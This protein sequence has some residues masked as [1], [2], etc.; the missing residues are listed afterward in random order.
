M[1][2]RISYLLIVTM[3]FMASGCGNVYSG[4]SNT[5]SDDAIYEDVQKLADEKNWSQALTEIATLSAGRQADSDVI[6]TWA[7]LLAGKCGLDFITYFNTISNGTLTGSTPIKFLMNAFTQVAVDPGS[8]ELAQAKLEEISTDPN[9]RTQ[10]ENLFMAILGMVKIGTY[11]RSV[12]DLDGPGGLG[13]GAADTGSGYDSCSTTALTDADVAQVVTGIGLVSNNSSALSAVAGS[14]DITTAMASISAVC[15]ST[16][17]KT[18]ASTVTGTD[19]TLVRDILKTGPSTTDTS[20]Q[21]GIDDQ[22]NASDG[23]TL[24]ACC[25]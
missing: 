13:D 23:V 9:Q 1:K 21:L 25:P 2:K 8:C 24:L 16:C 19:I 5:T 14:S 7:G 3:T 22:C 20:Y 17:A 18:D 10:S 12:A 15:G 11:L 6:E 4:L